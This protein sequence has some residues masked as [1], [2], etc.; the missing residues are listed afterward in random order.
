M[1][2]HVTR[3][4]VPSPEALF[5]RLK[6]A[7]DGARFT[8]DGP[9]VREL[10]T[11]VRDALGVPHG[12][13]TA[14]GTLALQLACAGLRPGDEVL[15]TPISFVATSSAL[16]WIGLEPVFVDVAP[17]SFHLDPARC[18]ER[19]GPRTRAI[20]ATHVYGLPCDVD[21][22][23]EVAE[24]HGLTLVYDAAHAFGCRLRGRALAAF[25]D[26]S[27][28]SFHATKIFHTGEGGFLCSADPE[29]VRRAAVQRNFGFD[30]LDSFRLGGF[31]AKMSELHAALGLCVL[32]LV[33]DA[34]AARRVRFERYRDALA[35]V[36]DRLRLPAPPDDL[37]YNY[38]YFPVV[39][40]DE[41]ALLRAWRRL[42]E[43]DVFARRYFHPPLSE[44]PYL[45][46]QDTPVAADL[47][48][49]VLCLPLYDTLALADVERIARVVAEALDAA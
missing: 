20:V 9:L 24:Q 45:A 3:S 40:P 26:V 13:A 15:T 6:P 17:G 21:G 31:N 4:L 33:N 12:V 30:G 23:A 39:F 19:I 18:A 35:P 7:F 34:I 14:N 43:A 32:P 46:R 38:A 44:L 41:P 2:I 47:C 22:L 42:V 49:R 11:R 1:S 5:E 28:L 10:E 37:E 29:R 48:P 16:H 25:G 8:N 27:V 36:A